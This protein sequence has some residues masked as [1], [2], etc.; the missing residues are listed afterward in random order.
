MAWVASWRIGEGS[1]R[2]APVPKLVSSIYGKKI[3]Y[4]PGPMPASGRWLRW[5]AVESS[6]KAI[7]LTP[8]EA[9]LAKKYLKGNSIAAS[10]EYAKRV[11]PK[12]WSSIPWLR[13]Q[14]LLCSIVE[15]NFIEPGGT[16]GSPFPFLASKHDPVSA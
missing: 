7:G 3:A 11:S 13:F 1:L 6:I 10:Q 9:S 8:R 14:R 4:S 16:K 2:I 15:T 5:E 12:T